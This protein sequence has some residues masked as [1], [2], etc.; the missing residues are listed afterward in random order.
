[1]LKIISIFLIYICAGANAQ[2]LISVYE[3]PRAERS[4]ESRWSA[5]YKDNCQMVSLAQSDELDL[6]S[7]G[8][9]R[10][11]D[12]SPSFVQ[13]PSRGYQ[14]WEGKCGQTLASNL[15]YSLCKKVVD[16][17]R[18]FTPIFRDI[19]PGVRP[20]TFVRGMKNS[21][22]R[23]GVECP[24]LQ[25]E[26]S[27]NYFGVSDFITGIKERL[28]PRYSQRNQL[29]INRNGKTYV[30]NPV[31]LLIQNPG[32]FELHWVM[33]IDIIEQKNK[34]E[35]VI[36][37]WDN[38]YQVPCDIVQ[39]WSEKVGRTYPIVLKSFTTVSYY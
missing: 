9:R 17:D 31:G 37:H 29:K 38:Q 26:W 22:P 28:T 19:T 13:P 11:R 3:L 2:E 33:A 1:M 20:G 27:I 8:F 30:R 21:F 39:G 12:G 24:L 35:L 25:G 23:L 16:P 18:Y 7:K 34:C 14:G 36:N 4:F 15:V 32:S 6:R 10:C 5:Y